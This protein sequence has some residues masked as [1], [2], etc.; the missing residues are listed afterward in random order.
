VVKEELLKQ[1]KDDFVNVLDKEKVLGILLFGSYANETQTNRSD[2]DICVVAP[3]EDSFDLYFLFLEK[4]NVVSK[5]YDIKFFTELPLYLKIQVIENGILVH[6]PNEL[7]LYE[8][9][10]R[11]RKLWA[12]QKHRQE[13]SKDELLSLLD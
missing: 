6:S 5:H 8:Y 7:D 11:F 4:I 12:D 1:I 9:F 10:Y 2:V 13:L 3:E